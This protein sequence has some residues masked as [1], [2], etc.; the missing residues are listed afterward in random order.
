MKLF[1]NFSEFVMKNY[2][3]LEK[4]LIDK[5]LRVN[6]SSELNTVDN[7]IGGSDNVFGFEHFYLRFES[8]DPYDI[9]FLESYY[10][11]VKNEDDSWVLETI[12]ENLNEKISIAIKLFEYLEKHKYLSIKSHPS[13]SI[14]GNDSKSD[15]MIRIFINKTVT[16]L[17]SLY[18]LKN[19][20]YLTEEGIKLINEK[21]EVKNKKRNSLLRAS[22]AVAMSGLLLT[23]SIS[24]SNWSVIKNN[25][26]IK[27]E[28]TELVAPEYI[29]KNIEEIE[30]YIEIV[31]LIEQPETTVNVEIA[32][33]PIK[34]LS[35][36]KVKKL[37]VRQT[38]S[39]KSQKVGKLF[40]GDSVEIIQQQGN[41][42]QI[43]QHQKSELIIK[44]WV[45]SRFLNSNTL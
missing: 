1:G 11:K 18:E 6:D 28:N 39:V 37:N 24:Y 20:N 30:E 25:N 12:S 34:E 19:N 2:T 22:V 21:I 13:N 35:I 8:D 10:E 23:T 9:H 41:W 45:L 4:R 26:T 29:N 16:A 44:G 31:T 40:L 33:A 38:A 43:G 15:K 14:N 42:V 27:K 17:D 32:E 5:I 7:I 36:V 3:Q